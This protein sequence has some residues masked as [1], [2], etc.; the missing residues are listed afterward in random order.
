MAM[1]P[2]AEALYQI[3][4]IKRQD[5]DRALK[6]K[7]TEARTGYY[8][9]LGTSRTTA[10]PPDPLKH[11]QKLIAAKKATEN[12]DTATGTWSIRPGFEELN[13][14]AT[15]AIAQILKGALE[16]DPLDATSPGKSDTKTG[17]AFLAEKLLSMPGPGAQFGEPEPQT[18]Q[19]MGEPVPGAMTDMIA[20][21][22]LAPPQGDPG[23]I[24]R[25][26]GIVKKIMGGLGNAP[27]PPSLMSPNLRQPPA[28]P[29]APAASPTPFFSPIDQTGQGRTLGEILAA[30]NPQAQAHG[31]A[32]DY[33]GLL[34]D[35]LEG[36]KKGVKKILDKLTATQILKE[37]G[38][39]KEKARKIARQRGYS[40]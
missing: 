34:T 40:F 23:R 26:M 33:F 29:V 16:E 14:R 20:R 15:D 39:D 6:N 35:M 19:P 37:A 2:I 8:N 25:V 27:L 17:L 13:K 4:D 38:G 10:Q 1:N 3:A 7:E 24:Q 11:L 22:Q 9:R 31:M 21:D 5:E 12:Y 30:Q 36:T 28:P 18:A 32:S